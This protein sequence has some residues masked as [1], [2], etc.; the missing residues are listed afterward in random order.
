M[1]PHAAIA[2]AWVV[3]FLTQVT[4]IA[5]GFTAVHRRLGVVG[6]MLIV[7]FAVTGNR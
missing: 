7:G 2:L 5:T 1:T 4:L 6:P 3:L